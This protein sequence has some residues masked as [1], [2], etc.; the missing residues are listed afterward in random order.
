VVGGHIMTSL[1][2]TNE[3]EKPLLELEEIDLPQEL[4]QTCV[5]YADRDRVILEQLRLEHLNKEQ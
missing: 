5:N 4:T 3:N 1:L 2:N